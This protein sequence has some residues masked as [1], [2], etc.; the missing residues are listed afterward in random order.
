MSTMKYLNFLLR[1]V[2]LWALLSTS[3]AAQTTQFDKQWYIWHYATQVGT[4][5]KCAFRDSSGRVLKEIFYSLKDSAVQPP[6]TEEMM[7]VQS[8]CLYTYNEQGYKIR[9]EH[10]NAQMKLDRV[11]ESKY[12]NGKERRDIY[13]TPEGVRQHEQ[14]YVDNR[15]VCTLYYDEKGKNLVAISGSIPQDID[16]AFGWG[17]AVNDLACGIGVGYAESLF[18]RI[19]GYNISISIRNLGSD[20]VSV[21]G[22]PTAE[23]ELRDSSGLRV[24]EKAEYRKKKL[25]PMQRIRMSYGWFIPSGTSICMTTAYE[26]NT[27]Y[28]NLSPGRYSIRIKQPIR[29]RG[30]PLLSNTVY[31]DV[32]G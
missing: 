1:S 6:Y 32:E 11:C 15:S 5:A 14:R 13:Y 23:I 29:G 17:E 25:D 2:L 16:L 10:F 18:D 30:K 7:K 22:L 26:L 9:A 24:R 8:I 28:G 19:P 21:T 31:F 4:V 12:Y 27:R 3:P 20:P